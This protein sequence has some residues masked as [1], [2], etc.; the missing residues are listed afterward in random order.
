MENDKER[1]FSI[2]MNGNGYHFTLFRLAIF[3][4]EKRVIFSVQRMPEYDLLSPLCDGS[5]RGYFSHLEHFLTADNGTS[6][7]II[8]FVALRIKDRAWSQTTEHG[9][10]IHNQLIKHSRK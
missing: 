7:D 9:Y 6:A 3:I 8:L 10:H 1:L 2:E 4:N 5:M